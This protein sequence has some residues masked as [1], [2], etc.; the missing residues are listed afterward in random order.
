MTIVFV[1]SF[2]TA[3][4]RSGESE[5]ALLVSMDIDRSPM[6]GRSLIMLASATA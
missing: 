6:T 4:V 2:P 1:H 3:F 5:V